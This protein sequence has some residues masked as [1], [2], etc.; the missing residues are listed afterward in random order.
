[1]ERV[2][3][4]LFGA[5]EYAAAELVDSLELSIV[6]GCGLHYTLH[7]IDVPKIPMTWHKLRCR[8]Q[9]VAPCVSARHLASPTSPP[10][11]G[12]RTPDCEWKTA[13]RQELPRRC[14]RR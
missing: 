11:F 13:V 8:E 6:T 1:M 7:S 2:T 5:Q 3:T 4:S 14:G 9:T 12:T 10:P